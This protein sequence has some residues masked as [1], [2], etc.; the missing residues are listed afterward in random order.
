MRNGRAFL[1]AAGLLLLSGCGGGGGTPS[2]PATPADDPLF[3]ECVS[4]VP[5]DAGNPNQPVISLTGPR[6]VNQ[7]AGTPYVDAR[8]TATDPKDGD[9]TNR[10]VVT[11]LTTLNTNAVGD[12]MVRYNV[13][14]SA[15]LRAVEA[16]RMVRVNAGTFT[17]LTARDIG[18]TS[19]HMGYNEHLPVH[20]SD[21]P[22]QKFPLIVFQHGW[23]HARFLNAYTVQV[24]LSSLA[25]VN[26]SGLISGSYGQWDTT[27]PFIVLEPQSCLDALTYVV[28]AARMKLFIDYAIHTYKV[29]TTRIYMGG[30]SQGSGDTWDYI[31]NYTQQLAA[32]FPISGGYGTSVGCVLKNTPAWAFN[33]QADTTVPYQ[34]QVD[35][36]NSI[37]AC[38][39]VERA[40]V[41]I[42]PGAGHDDAETDVLTLSALG[43][44]MPQYDI[45]D[46]SIYDWLLSHR[47]SGAAL[48]FGPGGTGA[49]DG[50]PAG[51][52]FAV[53]PEEIATGERATLKWSFPGAD[54]CA[55]SGDWLWTREARFGNSRARD[56]RLAQLCAGLRRT[57]R[58]SCANGGVDG[59]P[60]RPRGGLPGGGR[61]PRFLCRPLPARCA[62]DARPYARRARCRNA[63]GRSS[64][65][66][67]AGRKAC[68]GREV[69]YRLSSCQCGS[70]V[71]V[72]WEREQSMPE[73]PAHRGWL[74]GTRGDTGG[75]SGAAG[76][77]SGIGRGVGAGGGT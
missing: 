68:P 58:N 61:G 50:V 13:T 52:E 76:L 6:V 57:G 32:V 46:Q 1:L 63:R 53:T 40:K 16:A 26:L 3:D 54:S 47:R 30:H 45:Y 75:V 23:G 8:A 72:S 14:D 38:N 48:N 36:V 12:Y 9:I 28:T 37:N 33:G 20:Y 77:E 42:V 59:A 15:N 21:D 73:D 19:A 71:D 18:S 4:T 74:S 70:G 44:G 34:N 56:A 64:R 43:Q 31:N 39:P 27:R 60:T 51:D 5:V 67:G 7:P 35:T 65:G 49:S 62:G 24:P 11:G 29:D 10:I 41:T 69:G 25:T 2:Q 22:N 17:A 55:A 66:R